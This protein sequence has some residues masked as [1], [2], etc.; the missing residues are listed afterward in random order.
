LRNG[1]RALLARVVEAEVAEF[2]AKHAD[3]KTDYGRQWLV[4]HGYL[5]EREIGIAHSPIFFYTMAAANKAGKAALK[6]LLAK[7]NT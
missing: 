7:L 3:L 1:A 5:P 4:G 2:L 6:H